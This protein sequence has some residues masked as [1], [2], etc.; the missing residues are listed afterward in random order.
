MPQGPVRSYLA[1]PVKSRAGVVLG[2][3]FFGH[4]QPGK[5]T[6]EHEGLVEGIAAQAAVA[7][8]N[9]ALYKGLQASEARLRLVTDN[10]PVLLVHCDREGRFRFVNRPCAERLGLSTEDMVGRSISEILG[11]GGYA[12]IEPHVKKVLAGTPVTFEA[13][14]PYRHVG[15]RYIRAAYVPEVDAK[16]DVVGF[17]AAA[18]D[19]TDRRGT[20]IALQ[21][22]EARFRALHEISTRLLRQ[23]ALPQL[24]DAV[25]EAAMELTRAPK[26]N[27]QLHDEASRSLRIAAH[28]G[29]GEPFVDQFAVVQEGMPSACAAA[30]RTRQRVIVKDITRSPIFAGTPAEKLL[31]SEGSRAIQSTPIV[32]RSGKVL[33]VLSTYWSEPHEPDEGALFTLDLLARE[34]ADLIE[35]RQIEET[36]RDADRRKDEFLAML[37]HE[38]RNPLAPITTA[39][40]LVRKRA[41][42][43]DDL[44]RPLAIMSRQTQHL[45][46]L[47]DDLLEVS[48]ITRGKIRLEREVLDA[49]LAVS[50]AVEISRP[51]IDSRKHFLRVSLPPE[52][53]WLDADLTRLAQVL[54]NLLNNAAKY[55]DE[56]G[57][58]SL[59]LGTEGDEVV[60]RV[61]D[62]GIGIPEKLLPRLFELFTQAD[63]SLDRSQGGLGIGLTLVRGLVELHGG[64][65]K[66]FSDGAGKGSEFVVRLPRAARP[67]ARDAVHPF[68]W[69]RA[70][71]SLRIVVVDDN[72]DAAASLAEFLSEAGHSVAIAHDG[73]SSIDLVRRHRPDVVILDIGLPGLDGYEVARRLR[74]EHGNSFALVALTGYGQEEDRRRSREAGFDHHLVKPVPLDV[75]SKLLAR[76]ERSSAA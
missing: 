55:T 67:G 68:G 51:L 70:P 50:R 14:V 38:L 26:G 28:R 56:G 73:L 57:R 64:N 6:A 32:S 33:G 36:L 74:R 22:S 49:S 72:L 13:E 66:A 35:Q 63:D 75:L 34:A 60:F 44:A 45:S 43:R 59:S 5:F 65:V 10:A 40:Q 53:V 18:L 69:V 17:V 61:R 19:I 39:L 27:L 58:I 42:D 24:L 37:A 11:E 8:D 52:P 47:V 25:L 29:F 46:R 12:V 3:L 2:G 62:N 4:S 23:E 71:V 48:R 9:A 54:G 76:S 15:P 20:E 30:L 41:S 21:E 7:L 1:L 31:E 16:G